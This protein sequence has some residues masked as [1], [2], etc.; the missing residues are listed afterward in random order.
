[1]VEIGVYF[2]GMYHTP[3]LVGEPTFHGLDLSRPETGEGTL[4]LRPRNTGRSY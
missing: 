4:V 2:V 3:G 1:M